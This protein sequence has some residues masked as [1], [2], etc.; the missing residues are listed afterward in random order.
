MARIYLASSW[1]NG[2][3]GETLEALRS[4]GHQVYN[5]KAREASPAGGPV[6]TAFS[7]AE[8]DPA[9]QAWKPHAYRELLTTHPRAA[10]GFLGDMRGMEWA[11][12][13]VMLLPCGR[14]AH[15]EA[16][17]M[18][19]R[20]K[21]LVIYFPNGDREEPDLMY[22]MA[23]NIAIGTDDLRAALKEAEGGK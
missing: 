10:S 23:D 11:D 1:R 12:T 13:C 3:H 21:R 8:I 22:L 18:K 17:H 19:G 20:G 14:S 7:W 9:W 4:W 2:F 6:A 5:F 16:G 15:L